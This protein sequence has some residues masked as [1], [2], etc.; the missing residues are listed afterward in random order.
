LKSLRAR[1]LA[2]FLLPPLLVLTAA[3]FLGFRSSRAALEEELG[4]SMSATAGAIASQLSVDRVLELTP[5]DSEGEGS[6]TFN[7]LKK[8]LESARAAADLRRVVVFDTEGKVRLDAGG[9]LRPRAEF[10]ELARDRLELGRVFEGRRAAS[11]VLFEGNDG[12]HYKTGYAPLFDA[13]KKVVGA[14]AVEGSAGFFAPLRQLFWA[15]VGVALATLLALAV[16][17][18]LFSRALSRPLERLVESALRIG[19][20]DLE[21]QVP[22]ESSLEIG[23]LARELE[24]MRASLRSRD[25]QLKLMLGGV[26]HEVRNPLGGIELFG[27]LL[28]E[29]L[30][31][32]KPNL[33]EGQAHLA[34]IRTELDY[35]K[36]LVDDFLA[37]ARE[38]RLQKAPFEAKEWLEAAA[39]HVTGDATKKQVALGIE[40][41]GATLEGD[42]SLLTSAVVNLL[43]N[44]V[45]ASAEGKPVALRGAVRDGHYVV[46]V[47]DQGAGI[48]AETQARIFEPFFTT[49][50]KGSGLGLP[51]ARKLAEAHRGTLTLESRP[52]RTCFRLT[53]PAGR[54]ANS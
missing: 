15:Y 38:Q 49:R 12:K 29:E 47:E 40:A 28:K 1:L 39:A 22:A 17:A 44:A 9:S 45:Q 31:S 37:F 16:S 33:E 19:G 27:G 26:A 20:G 52:G 18:L 34:R 41:G 50:E 3:G 25:Q 6:R 42:V 21:T 7:R 4:T 51:L 13:D 14:V 2:V 24:S 48:P 23:I 35:L 54:T 30:A 5:E 8:E 32:E 11:Q 43:K 53:L 36:R 46:E 10:P